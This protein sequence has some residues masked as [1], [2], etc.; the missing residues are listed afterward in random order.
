[1]SIL[2]RLVAAS[3]LAI[4]ALAPIQTAEADS[5]RVRVDGAGRALCSEI[6]RDIKTEP[7]AVAN[8]VLHWAYGYMTRRNVERAV[9]G[10]SQV[11]IGATVD[12]RQL[13]GVILAV[14]EK[15]PSMRLFQVVDTLYE[16]LL[17]KGSLT[18]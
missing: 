15:E 12:D 14:C 13:L 18:S 16:V 5:V 9:A 8:A 10:Q 4:A 3:L 7:T 11:D 17:E 6:T 1:M 2:P